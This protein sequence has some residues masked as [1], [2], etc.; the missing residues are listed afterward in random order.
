MAEG[1]TSVERA[2][3]VIHR[4]L[5]RLDHMIGNVRCPKVDVGDQLP[6]CR[7][8]S[9][10]A[11]RLQI[12]ADE[13]VR[14]PRQPGQVH[15]VCQRHTTRVDVEDLQAS[16]LV[17]DGNRQ[18]AVKPAGPPQRRVHGVWDV[19]RTDDDDTPAALEPIHERQ[20][21]R[22]HTLFH[23]LVAAGFLALG[24]NGVDLVQEDNAGRPLL[25]FLEDLAQMRFRLAVKLVNDLR[26]CHRDKMGVGLV[27]HGTCDQCLAG[28]RRA[29]EQH[30]L[31]SVDAQPFKHL[32]VFQRQF[33]HLA[34]AL[35][36]PPQ[37][38]NIFIGDARAPLLALDLFAHLQ[39]RGPCH[40]HRPA[41]GDAFD[42]KVAHA[43]A[44][45]VHAHPV[46]GHKRS[47]FQQP[48]EILR[49]VAPGALCARHRLEYHR[50]GIGRL[51]AL[52]PLPSYPGSPRRSHA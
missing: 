3:E 30:A 11:Q 23:L 12:G 29:I 25:G 4:Y 26:P 48:A 16:G 2:A 45:Q 31:G 9:L 52:T 14:H 5:Q 20:Q 39:P 8:R 21:L 40:D 33:D 35:D 1:S 44:H 50:L 37:T 15:V 28:S 47:P 42:A 24:R 46:T 27:G 10:A 51:A 32:R 17:G 49:L 41:W 6:Q 38:T 18:L 43:G 34:N 19:G 7:H 22:D 36:L 13:T